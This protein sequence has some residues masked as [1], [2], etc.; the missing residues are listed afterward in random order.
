MDR[1]EREE[2]GAPA[3]ADQQLLVVQLLEVA[4]E[5]REVSD[6]RNLRSALVAK[7]GSSTEAD[8]VGAG[9]A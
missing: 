5:A 2:A 8:A 4:G 6:V 9:S 3:A 1:D 7:T